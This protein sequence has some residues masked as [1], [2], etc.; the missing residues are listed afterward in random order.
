MP[1]I[2]TT[3]T[4]VAATAPTFQLSSTQPTPSTCLPYGWWEPIYHNFRY[5]A[6]HFGIAVNVDRTHFSGFYQQGAGCSY[7]AEIN[8]IELLNSW[9]TKRWQSLVVN[10]TFTLPEILIDP[11]I[12][13]Q[14]EN[15]SIKAEGKVRS[16]KDKTRIY[17]AMQ[18]RYPDNIAMHYR[19]LDCQI[20]LFIDAVIAL[21]DELNQL[22]FAQLQQSYE[23]LE[24]HPT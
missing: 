15:G 2:H 22:L 5:L 6:S 3:L 16:F 17:V 4:T 14:L 18:F 21:C 19:A 10:S 9:Q 7:E 20:E 1:P 23:N 11:A 12:L 8:V 13:Q 24:D